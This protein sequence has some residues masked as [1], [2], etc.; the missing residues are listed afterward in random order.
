M[1]QSNILELASESVSTEKEEVIEI[2]EPKERERKIP[3]MTEKEQA[4]YRKYGIIRYIRKRITLNKNFIGMITGQTGSGKSYTSMSIAEM[5]NEDFNISRLVFKGKDLMRIINLGEHHYRK[6]VVIVWDEAG[7][8]LSNRNWYSI[9]NKVLSF[10]VQTFRHKNF[11]LLFTVPYADFV[12][13]A[14]K[15][16]FHAEFETCG[17]DTGKQTVALKP[18]FLQYNS[19]K[20]KWYRKYLKVKVKGSGKRIKIRRWNVPKPSQTLIDE[21]EK[22]KNSFTGTLNKEIEIALQQLEGSDTGKISKKK[23][24]TEQQ[25]IIVELWKMGIT[26]KK[27]VADSLGIA[28]NN[29]GK[30]YADLFVK[31]HN[32][33]AYKPNSIY[34][35][36]YIK[37][38]KEEIV[39]KVNDVLRS[40]PTVQL[41]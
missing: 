19:D 39:E 1:G 28:R 2:S 16:L 12:D 24:L 3:V 15:K 30:S 20:K 37:L 33:M 25:R 8:D 22:K 21:Y 29:I 17:I 13:T 26:D 27:L 38:H 4:A 11:I 35:E 18:K 31:G 41:D 32:S 9:T 40:L 14:T 6:G 5:L 10:L 36:D 23:Y 34:D 7:I